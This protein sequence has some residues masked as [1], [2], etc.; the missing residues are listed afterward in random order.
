MVGISE[1]S[2]GS[3]GPA[4]LLSL[5]REMVRGRAV[6]DVIV[7]LADE[8]AF[9][10]FYH[11]GVG[12]E[13]GPVGVCAHL[14]ETDALFYAHRG[15][16]Y[17]TAKGMDPVEII[18]DFLGTTAGSTRG[19]GAGTVHCVDPERGVYGQGGTLG[20]CFPL[21]AG[22]ALALRMQGRDDVAVAFFGDGASARGTFLE[23]A[24]FAVAKALPVVFV[25]ENNGFAISATTRESQGVDSIAGRARGFGLP[26]ET[27]DGTDVEAVWA[28]AGVAIGDVG[29]LIH[30]TT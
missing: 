7:R 5:Y 3:R 18:G 30:G 27:V 8:R 2:A 4:P 12:Q 14:R 17:L 6:E 23:A 22:V 15:V 11:P 13:A 24:V 25:C 16:A 28:A 9:Q 29:L 10:G 20:S 26:A 1:Q 19:L 21:A